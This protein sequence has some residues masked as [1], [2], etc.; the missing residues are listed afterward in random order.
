MRKIL[1]FLPIFFTLLLSSVLAQEI[2]IVTPEKTPVVYAG[3]TNEIHVLIR[4]NMEEKASFYF[5]VWPPQWINLK[6][7]WSI[8]NA[9]ETIN[10]T[11]FIQPP[12]DAE[13]GTYKYSLSVK[14]L[15]KNVSTTSDIYINVKRTTHVIISEIKLNKQILRPNE[16]LEI[17]PVLTNLD[18]NSHSVL[19]SI[20]ILKDDLQVKKFEDNVSIDGK[21]SLSLTYSFP[22]KMTDRPGE[23]EIVVSLRNEMNKLLDETTTKFSIE[24]ISKLEQEKKVENKLLYSRV[25]IILTNKGNVPE[26]DVVI[27]E[28]LP[29]ILK[30]FFYPEI[31]PTSQEEKENRI[32][33]RWSIEEIPPQQSFVIRYQ[34]RFSSVI[35]VSALFIIAIIWAV[36]TFYRPSLLKRYVAIF[37]G[38]KEITVSLHLKNRGKSTL[39]NIVVKDF[40]PAIAAVVKKFDTIQ[41]TIKRKST[42]TELKWRI[43]RLEPKEERILTYRI[44]PIVEIIGKIKLPR[45]EL[46]YETKR[47]KVRRRISKIISITQKIE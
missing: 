4:N 31:E 14:V 47:G 29:L 5:S 19:L 32:T 13:E 37:P 36:W 41:P 22:I 34:L 7:Y 9:G 40:V 24:E 39:K 1:I 28:T 43:K 8:I 25:E 18:V 16:T 11:L 2:Q 26:R 46:I 20:K 15:E 17:T 38:P 6:K 30:N 44:R 3:R 35:I 21:K 45:A 42:G 33:Y 10:L 12:R 27:S 23:Y